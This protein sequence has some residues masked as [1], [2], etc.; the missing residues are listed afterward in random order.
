MKNFTLTTF[1]SFIVFAIIS[2]T[3]A[4]GLASSASF[5]P[6]S[7]TPFSSISEF[8]EDSLL[9]AKKKRRSK[10]KRKSSRSKEKKETKPKLPEPPPLSSDYKAVALLPLIDIEAGQ[11]LVAEFEQMISNEIDELKGF[12][13]VSPADVQNDLES[14]GLNASLC[15]GET[16][17]IAQS[18]RYARAH[19]ALQIRVAALGGTVSVAMVL[20]DTQSSKELGRVAESVSDNPGERASELHHLAIQLLRPKTYIGNLHIESATEGADVYIDDKL[21]GQTPLKADAL[22]GLRAGPHILR[23]TKEGFDDIHQFVDV[24]YKRSSTVR[25]DLDSNIISGVIVEAESTTGFGHITLLANEPDL[26]IRIDGEP[27]GQTH[28][29]GPITDIPAGMRKIS[30][31]KKGLEP[32][33]ITIEIKEGMRSEMAF[34]NIDGKLS[35]VGS[36]EVPIDEPPATTID[37]IR[38]IEEIIAQEEGKDGTLPDGA[39]AKAPPPRSHTKLYAGI[40]VA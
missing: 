35:L 14:I 17:C 38:G 40:A 39:T 34:E 18:G 31:R 3:S 36:R 22:N 7:K 9:S 16:L 33:S 19:L 5:A 29:D 13:S 11:A 4:F 2:G 25:I 8:N 20:V 32:L 1:V 10:K 15:E 21:I 6:T 30:L 26:K 12:R 27:R 37:Q 23:V 24:I 28:L